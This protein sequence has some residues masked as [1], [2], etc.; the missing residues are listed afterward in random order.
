MLAH[1]ANLAE[2]G[3]HGVPMS[4]AMDPANAFKFVTTVVTD[5]AAETLA[6]DQKAYYD[7]WDK[8]PDRP[9]NRAGHL[10]RVRLKE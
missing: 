5:F 9:I 8:N 2:V 1:E 6:A 7:K 10:W 4:E 3:P